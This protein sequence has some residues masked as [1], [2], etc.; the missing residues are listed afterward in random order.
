MTCI[1]ERYNP[2]LSVDA[3]STYAPANTSLAYSPSVS[4]LRPLPPTQ[5]VSLT[6]L[7]THSVPVFPEIQVPSVQQSVEVEDLP[8]DVEEFVLKQQ[9]P[10]CTAPAWWES[11]L[12]PPIHRTLKER[13]KAIAPIQF[14]SPQLEQR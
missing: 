14:R 1:V 9:V 5:P 3:A 13:E 12:A 4:V 7:Q 11:E 8:S 2:R 6:K 10:T